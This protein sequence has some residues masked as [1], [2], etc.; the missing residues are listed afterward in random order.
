VLGGS[1]ARRDLGRLARRKPKKAAPLPPVP[2]PAPTPLPPPA[3]PAEATAAT[4]TVEALP[5]DPDVPRRLP[6]SFYCP[7]PP[8]VAPNTE[9]KLRCALKPSAALRQVLLFYRAPGSESF[10]KVIMERSKKG[11]Y[12]GVVPG[13][14]VTGSAVQIYL[15]AVGWGDKVLHSVGA[16]D[17]PTLIVIQGG[18]PA[19]AE[20]VADTSPLKAVAEQQERETRKRELGLHARDPKS[21]WLGLG[22]GYGGGWMPSRSLDFR[23]DGSASGLAGQGGMHFGGELGYQFDEGWAFGLQLRYQ[24][25][26]DEGGGDSAAK[27]GSPSHRA[28]AALAHGYRFYGEGNLQYFLSGTVGAGTAF[29]LYVAPNEAA[30]FP[31]SDS[32]VGGPV[33]L[34]PGA[35]VIYHF[36]DFVAAVGE[37][38]LLAGVPKVAVLAEATVGLQFS[39]WTK[40]TAGRFETDISDPRLTE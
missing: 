4:P 21:V 12:E 17:S 19:T 6:Q 25:V 16:S 23:D 30:G 2:A 32:V 35:G 3:E 11:W 24:L 15:Q 39:L 13:G 8:E 14:A 5:A 40:G 31:R 20:P 34:G 33:V 22:A 18:G 36:S 7:L 26:A 29:R 38:R 27:P 28:W 37:L 10:T 9:F 1:E